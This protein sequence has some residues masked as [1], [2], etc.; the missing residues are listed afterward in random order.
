MIDDGDA[1]AELLGLLE[2]MRG[3]QHGDAAGVELAHI[4]PELLAQLH[5]DAGGGLVQH[6]HRRV[7]H[8][9]LGH[10]QPPAHAAREGAGI[11]IGLV[12]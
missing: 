10:Q 2:I 8:Q 1:V 5:I 9:R 12:G 6:Q 3:Q 4:A 11:G 7:V